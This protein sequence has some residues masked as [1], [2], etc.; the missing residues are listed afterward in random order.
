MIEIIEANQDEMSTIDQNPPKSP[1]RKGGLFSMISASFPP[2]LKER[3]VDF[4][5]F[6]QS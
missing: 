5:N 3:Q 6:C 4:F 1:F 2:F